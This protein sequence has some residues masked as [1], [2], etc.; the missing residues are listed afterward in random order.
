M[1]IVVQILKY[2]VIGNGRC[3]ISRVEFKVNEPNI[4]YRKFLVITKDT[5]KS[6]Y[7]VSV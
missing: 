7:Y 5:M 6:F 1:F 3:V 2:I 4:P